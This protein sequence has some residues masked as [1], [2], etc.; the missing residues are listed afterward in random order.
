LPSILEK[1]H[2][3]IHVSATDWEDAIRQAGTVLLEAGSIQSSYIDRMI[4]SVHELG[5]YIVILPGL[6][7]AHAAP[8][9]AVKKTD[10]SLITLASPVNFGSPND[11]VSVVLCLACT[12]S[13]SHIERLSQIANTL[14]EEDKIK[15]LCAAESEEDL[16]RIFQLVQA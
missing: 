16:V 7:L 5:P 10:I 13:S 8:C 2:V 11:P 9:D 6:A 4:Q 14:M 15:Q 1:N 12:D 3:R